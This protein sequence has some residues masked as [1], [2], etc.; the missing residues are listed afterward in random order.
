MLQSGQGP[1]GAGA[2]AANSLNALLRKSKKPSVRAVAVCLGPNF[3]CF[4]HWLVYSACP[5]VHQHLRRCF[6]FSQLFA[7]LPQLLTA[8]Q[9]EFW[10]A[11]EKAGWMQSQG[12]HIRTWRRRWFVLKQVCS[13]R[14]CSALFVG[15]STIALMGL[16]SF[17]LCFHWMH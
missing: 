5:P 11:P 16:C 2:A 12:E 4:A 1:D 13:A 15:L 3:A 9:V 17:G 14:L 8:D 7:A 10:R 6:K